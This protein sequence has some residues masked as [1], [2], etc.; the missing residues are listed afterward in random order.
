ME[1]KGVS[2][3]LKGGLKVPIDRP[4]EDIDMSEEALIEALRQIR[5]MGKES[6]K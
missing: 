1:K 6:R 4:A 2:F 5:E 3:L